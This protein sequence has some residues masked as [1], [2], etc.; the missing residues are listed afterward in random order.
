MKFIEKKYTVLLFVAIIA[1]GL[2]LCGCEFDEED[3]VT[4]KTLD[5]YKTEMSV[6]VD[7]ELDVVENSV[8]G[9]NDGD[10]RNGA[11]FEEYS[12]NYS[13]A[14]NAAKDMLNAPDLSIA[15]V[16]DANYLIS[17][18][19]KLFNDEV[20]MSDRRPLDELVRYCDTLWVNT[21]VGTESGEVS[22]EAHDQFGTAISSAKGVR[23]RMTTIERQVVQA[24][25]ELNLEL[26]IFEDAI[27]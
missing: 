26:E 20:F 27:I 2:G 18:P 6:L 19:G 10:F 22:Q 1:F 3:P 17:S 24:V 14:L 21:P 12:T 16:M 9:Y 4:P 11:L 7:S 5:Q 25:D 8:V 23:S 15:D 13:T